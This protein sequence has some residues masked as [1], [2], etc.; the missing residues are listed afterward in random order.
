MSIT[1]SVPV[2][3]EIADLCNKEDFRLPH[4]SNLASL[5]EVQKRSP[6][7]AAI[8]TAM[9]ILTT[10]SLVGCASAPNIR[11]GRTAMT[12]PTF[13]T[14]KSGDSLSKIANRYNLDY[15][16]IARKNQIGGDYVIN[17]G[18]R[19]R[20][21]G[22]SSVASAQPVAM[23][24]EQPLSAQPLSSSQTSTSSSNLTSTQLANQ[25]S[26]ASYGN[27][28][29]WP[30]DNLIAQNFDLSR[31]VKGVRFTGNAG[32]P[33]KA[34]ADGTVIYSSNGLSEYGN[35]ILIQHASGYITAYAHNQRLLV[36][37]KTRVTAGQ[38]IA[39]MGSTGT[40]RVMLEFQVRLNGKP[41]N[42]MLVLPKKS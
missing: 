36:Q 27:A 24:A 11:S 29:N 40:N 16:E 4:F 39:E 26:A 32:D 8:V 20:L 9:V 21:V 15:R 19:L 42:P 14:V 31:Q 5:S 12:P 18:Q 10:A 35:L 17:V 7:V 33:V 6:I 1:R 13:Y 3:G 37:E 41:M 30:T 2:F 25:A 22:S 23:G 34:A 28:W 38:Q